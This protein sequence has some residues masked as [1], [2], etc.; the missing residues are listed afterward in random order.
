MKTD[1]AV[2]IFVIFLLVIG[3]KVFSILKASL[4]NRGHFVAKRK[5]S[6]VSINPFALFANLSVNDGILDEVYL[7]IYTSQ[8]LI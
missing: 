1:M 7:H 4:T 5:I 3:G 8:L 6:N 2:H